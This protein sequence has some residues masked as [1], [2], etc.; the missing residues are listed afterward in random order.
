LKD[1][2]VAKDKIDEVILVGGMTRM[3]LVLKKV[4]YGP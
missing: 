2:G 4:E 1:S 3:P